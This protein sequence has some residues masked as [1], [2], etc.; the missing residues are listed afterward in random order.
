VFVRLLGPVD[1]VVDGLSRP[2]TGVRRKAVLAVLALH[3]GQVVSADRLIDAVWGAASQSVA[4][5]TLQSHVSQLRQV[6]GCRAAI[7]ARSPGYLLDLDTGSTDVEVAEGLISE[8]RRS[9]DLTRR[10]EQLRAALGMWRGRP[11]ADVVGVVWVEGQAQRLDQLWLRATH[12]LIDTRL[13][14][15]E[16]ADLVLDLER[17][18]QE[19][20]LDEPIHRQL[21]LA[22]YRTNRQADAFAAYHRLR[23]ALG[24]ELGIDPGRALRDLEAAML[25]QDP[26]L[27]LPPTPI[28][29]APIT[30]PVVT[31]Q[32]VPAAA[33]IGP[34]GPRAVGGLRLGGAAVVGRRGELAVLEGAVHAAS[35]GSGEAVFLVGEAG[36]GKTRLA[37]EAARLAA[38][39]GLRV[40]RGRATTPAVQFRPLSEALLSVLRRSGP[41]EDPVLL[42]YR[43]ALS[44]LVPEWRVDRPEGVDDSLVVL[45]EAVLR[46]LM[47]LGRPR[48]CVLVLE[49]LHE[50]DTDTLAV[51]DYLIDNVGQEPLL[52]LGTV[53]T[54]PS[55]ALD[56]AGEARH[57]R[58]AGVI[59]LRRLD[60][61]EV[62]QLAGGCLDAAPDQVPAAVAERLLLTADGVPLHVEELLAGMI[63]DQVLVRASGRWSVT[64]PVPSQVP[65]T[66]AAT[67]AS[68]ANRLSPQGRTVLQVAAL[69]GRRFPAQPVGVAAGVTG[70]ELLS[71][72]H[73]AVEA[74]LVVPADGPEVYAFRHALTAEALR[75]RLLPLERVAF[76][77]RAAEAVEASAPVLS[78]GWEQLA[79]ELWQVAG[80]SR[81]AAGLLGVAGRRAA[82]QGAVAT[83]ISLLEGGLA[84]I[85][86]DQ[87]D[88]LAADLGEAL[89][90][91][92][93]AAGRVADAYALGARFSG[94]AV[95]GRRAAV[96]LQLARV[97]ASAGDWDR[98]LGELADVRR[99]LGAD[100]GAAL[101][102]GVDAVAA[103]LT[104]GKPTPQ[105]RLAA[106]RLADR[107]LAAAEATG[108][109]EVA[110]D[111]LR[112][113]GRCARLRDLAEA[114]AFYERG[115]VIAEANDLV[116][117]R[118]AL[119]YHLGA[120]DGIRD[121]D[122]GRLVRALTVANQAGAVVTALDIEL[123]IAVVQLC[124]GEYAAAEAATSRC[125]ETA[126]RLRLTHTRL[127]ALGER[128]IIAAH[129][130]RRS[131]MDTLMARF[132]EL[133]GE[134][135]DFS[136]A[137]RGL[138][139]AF[140]H[141]LDED[142]DQALAELSRA[143]AQEAQRP[144]SYLSFIHGPNLFLSVLAGEAGWA[145]CDALGRSA[146]VQAGW[147]QQF[148]LLA[149][150]LLA[151]RAGRDADAG[152]AMSR[153]LELSTRYPLAHH[154]GLRLVAPDA[155][156]HAWGDPVSWLRVAEEYLHAAGPE[157]ARACRGLL[158]R[159]G[160]PV[161]QH[162][163]GSHLI[164]TGARERGIT[165][166]EYEV[167]RLVAER[168]GNP[169]IGRRL[170]LSPRTVERHVAN[171]L[172]KTGSANRTVLTAFAGS[173]ADQAGTR[174]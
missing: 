115:L 28:T 43:S 4:V 23:R 117:Q 20:P 76:A 47:T 155:I 94:Q 74:Q 21:V 97:A 30:P 152:L 168:L 7:L 50:A 9:T 160:V 73:E 99:L 15:G 170:F 113:L 158:R 17:L 39:A 116:S 83:A 49:D 162:R 66:L 86:L 98:G 134:E 55:A 92:Y 138:G 48:G 38:D 44:R 108:Q 67:L 130:G 91:A 121:A 14:L 129:R 10:A 62:R 142:R 18:A 127:I 84:L 149:H 34:G 126:A 95:P 71:C 110:C 69:L 120:H 107:A 114:D 64:G 105:R 59:E 133:G 151:G 140:W 161:P 148:L 100:P 106:Q 132:G 25:R 154:L 87:G 32:V 136:A 29:P 131:E 118:V 165:V 137:V 70:L 13:A 89:V 157:A 123:E 101:S 167:L 35:R 26:A 146:Q 103:R 143:A 156:E 125:E 102:A 173:L 150:A 104:F 77:R 163:Q 6:L 45:A 60:D 93:A 2:V 88:E 82:A 78:E 128:I 8:G 85:E 27:H 145:E 46:L 144:A 141:L 63:S 164:P 171:L 53:R 24:E 22:L 153:Y 12:A 57:R 42:P 56:L 122:T 124:R 33:G 174:S 81:R 36:M 139:L 79:G 41:P 166:R 51:V 65:V 111:A 52:V 80:E 19:H 1:V 72:L 5:N 54:H 68:R 90:A 31:P 61:E 119:L 40:L 109:P 147:N 16:H 172:A 58:S 96:H 159:A 11:L 169:E 135:D 37:E 112:T 3:R 75:A